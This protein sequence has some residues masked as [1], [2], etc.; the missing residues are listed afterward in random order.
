MKITREKVSITNF[1]SNINEKRFDEAFEVF[2]PE[3]LWIILGNASVLSNYD[4]RK[5]C[6]GFKSLFRNFSSLAF[7][8]HEMIQE[9]NRVSVIAE[10]YALNKISNKNYNKYYHFLFEFQDNKLVKVR[11]Y[12]DTIHTNWIE[13]LDNYYI[14][15]IGL[16]VIP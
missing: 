11:E 16:Q 8:I 5:I 13:E 4:K 10:F 9:E 7:K 6:L 2:D 14:L 15:R 12:L 3:F 1:F